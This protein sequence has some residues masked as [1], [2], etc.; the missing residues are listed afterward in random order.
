MDTYVMEIRKL[1]KKF[2][3][4]E[5][6]H[7]VR[8]NDVSA[9][10]LL[11]PGSDR[12]N[13]PPGVFVHELRHSSIRAP[14]SSSIAQGPKELD[15]EVLMVEVNWRVAFI[16]YMQEHKLPSGIDPKSV[17]ATHILR[18]SKGYVVV[19][20][21]M[22]KHGSA[23][24][25]LMKCVST[26]EGKEIL[27]EIHE[28]VCGNHA[29]SRTL[30][31][32][33]FRSGFYWPTSLADI[34]A[35]VHQCTNCQF[36]GK[37]PHVSAHNL[38]TILPSWPFVCWRLDMIEPLTTAPEGFTHV[39]VAIDKFTKW[40]EYKPIATLIADRVITFIYDILHRFGFPNTII[41]DLGSNF[42]S[43]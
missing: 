38:I 10:V 23:S 12:G 36:F 41:T 43:Y 40:I 35:L 31:G 24:G 34:E 5:I 1:E 20:R 37:Q 4:L 6:H 18:R 30:V 15:R 21:N 7:V 2:S 13:I 29:A 26:E 25:I 8:D 22:Y 16:D 9:D 32:K 27:Q 39:L 3:G 19:G 42:H 11:N 14:N 33:A 28:G 17:E